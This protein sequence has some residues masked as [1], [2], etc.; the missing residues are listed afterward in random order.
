MLVLM[1]FH[2]DDS[3]YC[4][5]SACR[6]VGFVDRKMLQRIFLSAILF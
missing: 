3:A 4:I 2:F 5:C 6:S 1:E